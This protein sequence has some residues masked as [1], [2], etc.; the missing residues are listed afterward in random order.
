MRGGG[1]SRYMGSWP[2]EPR[3]S[4]WISEVPHSLRFRKVFSWSRLGL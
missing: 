4:L 3:R 2:G 1:F